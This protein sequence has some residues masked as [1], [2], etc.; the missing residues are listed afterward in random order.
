MEGRG[1]EMRGDMK[2]HATMRAI[3]VTVLGPWQPV[4][5]R[6]LSTHFKVKHLQSI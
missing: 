2:I 1:L 5:I 6:I 3:C 4:F